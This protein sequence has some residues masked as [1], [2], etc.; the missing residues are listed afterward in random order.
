MSRPTKTT[1]T[2]C[3]IYTRV[4]T[5]KRA[6]QANQETGERAYEQSPDMQQ[7][8]LEQL[9]V[10]RKWKVVEVY[11]DRASGSI[12]QRPGLERMMADARRH[13]F[14]A[15]LVW[16][17][18]RFARSV[19]QLVLALEE[20]NHLG[21]TFISLQESLDT[22]SPMGKAMFSIIAA[23]SELERDIMRER[24]LAG[25]AHAAEHGTKSGRPSGRPPR[26][27]D[28]QRAVEMLEAGEGWKTIAFRLGVSVSTLVRH[29]KRGRL[30][31]LV[32]RV[33]RP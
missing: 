2:L 23:L 25:M 29:V 5:A 15:V 30:G 10:A 33:E 20:F 6:A 17:F 26:V 3:A 21:I 24:I 14:Q 7:A 27:F 9:A 18:D 12:A 19:K 1:E 11:S 4:S 31:E 16:R 28:R 32:A 13:R 8:Q 22:S